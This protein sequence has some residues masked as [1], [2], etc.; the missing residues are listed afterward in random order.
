M[1]IA[2]VFCEVATRLGVTPAKGDIVFTFPVTQSQLADATGL[3][4]VH[5]N[6][7]LMALRRDGVMTVHG[8]T[9][10]IHDWE[11]LTEAGDFDPDYLQMDISPAQRV[12]IAHAA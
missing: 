9:V 4:P 3:T 10:W 6:R 12:R 2:H 1:R 8:Q 11:A 5:V 7:T